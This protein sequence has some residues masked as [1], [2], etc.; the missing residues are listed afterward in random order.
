MRRTTPDYIYAWAQNL[1]MSSAS[2]GSGLGP[3]A[4]GS[5]LP[6]LNAEAQTRYSVG[7]TR[8][9]KPCVFCS[10]ACS[11]RDANTSMMSEI[12]HN[13]LLDTVLKFWTL[14][15]ATTEPSTLADMCVELAATLQAARGGSDGEGS[16]AIEDVVNSIDADM[17]L[18]HQTRHRSDVEGHIAMLTQAL[19]T[20]SAA[21]RVLSS[22]LLIRGR[23]GKLQLDATAAH[24]LRTISA[25]MAT[26]TSAIN[27][28][29][30]A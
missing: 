25:T 2:G 14:N 13:T 11:P 22:N 3:K 1:Y 4:Q 24:Q 26:L 29:R 17:I 30:P 28:L 19:F 8:S 20:A 23:H 6:F 21:E 9:S 7:Q 15:A 18:T 16:D 10:F 27:R 5:I 12:E